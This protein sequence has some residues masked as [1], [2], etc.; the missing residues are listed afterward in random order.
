ML[1]FSRDSFTPAYQYKQPNT[2]MEFFPIKK[3][4]EKAKLGG[5]QQATHDKKPKDYGIMKRKCS[6]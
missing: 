6:V 1:S 5:L 4:K 3:I 2:T